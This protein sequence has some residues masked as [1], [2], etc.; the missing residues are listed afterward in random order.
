MLQNNSFHSFQGII[1]S[2]QVSLLNSYEENSNNT[3]THETISFGRDIW[4]ATV[5]YPQSRANISISLGCSGL[6]PLTFCSLQG[7][8]FHRPLWAPVP[9][10]LLLSQKI[11]SV[12]SS[13][14]S[15]DTTCGHCSCAVHLCREPGL[16]MPTQPQCDYLS[17]LQRHAVDPSS[18]FC[19][20]GPQ[21]LLLAKLLS[22][23]SVP[24]LCCHTGI[25][26]VRCRL[27]ICSC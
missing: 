13:G 9:V 24:S 1:N 10:Y 8:G 3:T 11:S 12:M 4:R 27:H 2:S 25:F 18:G 16:F 6:C 5:Q 20:P 17:L 21:F 19:P 22:D 14:I 23:H 7:W 26:H 15:L